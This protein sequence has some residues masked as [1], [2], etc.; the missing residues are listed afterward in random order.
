MR[1]LGMLLGLVALALGLVSPALA[2]N[3][4]ELT[5]GLSSL[6]TETLDPVLGGQVVKFY[7]SQMFEYLVGVTPDGKLSPDGGI[8]LKWE[9]SADHKRWTFVLRKGIKFHNGDE[10]TSED[11]KFSITRA[12]GKRSTTGYAQVLRELL[13][14]IETP[15]SD[16]IVIVTKDPTLI[17]PTFLSRVLSTEGMIL[18]KKYIEAKGDDGFAR[19][20]VGSGPYRF[21]E[22]VTGS[23]IKLEAV[24]NHWR[25]GTPKYKTMV[26]K[27]VPEETTRLAML[28]RGEID[29][30]EV[31]RERLDE[32]KKAGFPVYVRKEDAQADCWFVQSWDNTP[33][34]DKRVREALNIAIDRKEIAQGIFAGMADPGFVHFGLSW[35]FPDIKFKPGNE[36][37]YPYDPVRA[38]KLIAEAGYANG[39]PAEIYAYQLPGMSEGKALAEAVGGYWQKVG[40]QAKIIPVDYPAFRK[41]WMDRTAPGAMGCFNIANRDWLGTIS[42]I[43][44]YASFAAK[45]ASIHDAELDRMVAEVMRQTDQ[46]KVGALMRQI[47]MRLRSEHFGVPL[48]YLHTPYVTSKR[49]TKWNPGSVMYELNLDEMIAGK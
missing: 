4:P 6:S 30:L 35:S 48:V 47:F 44:K 13:K 24:D 31:A 14:D 1:S 32:V 15:A 11:V 21:V 7:L 25:L 8:A 19:A 5:I 40:V 38:K 22:Q 16:R 27:L 45:S 33:I 43:D 34:K 3:K 17:V 29:V 9:P 36:L 2:Q 20:P 46:E 26:F 41:K 37:L 49:I 23:H 10:L 18:P 12:L 42:I 39:M 28:R